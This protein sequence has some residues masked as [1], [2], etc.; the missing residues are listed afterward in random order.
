MD[1]DVIDRLPSA[2][3]DGIKALLQRK[4]DR[5]HKIYTESA[6]AFLMTADES[7]RGRGLEAKGR[8]LAYKDIL[9][10]LMGDKDGRQD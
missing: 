1:Q 6:D 8:E 3:T 7:A 5:E 2:F 10:Q 4:I 9:K